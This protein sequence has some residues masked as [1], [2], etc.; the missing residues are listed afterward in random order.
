MTANGSA[1]ATNWLDRPRRRPLQ[2]RRGRPAGRR[3]PATAHARRGAGLE[4]AGRSRSAPARRSGRRPS[5]SGRRR[6]R[7]RHVRAADGGIAPVV[8]LR[9][10]QPADRAPADPARL[11][12]NDRRV[13][14]PDER[15]AGDA[16]GGGRRLL[17]HPRRTGS[18]RQRRPPP[19]LRTHDRGDVPHAERGAGAPVATKQHSVLSHAAAPDDLSASTGACS[20]QRFC[21]TGSST[22]SS[23][24]ARIWIAPIRRPIPRWRSTPASLSMRSASPAGSRRRFRCGRRCIC[25]YRKAA[26]R[27]VRSRRRLVSRCG[28]CS[29]AWTPRARSSPPCSTP[30]AGIWRN[31]ACRARPARSARSRELLGYSQLSSFSR[32]FVGEFQD[33]ANHV[34]A[35]TRCRP[36][37]TLLR[38]RRIGHRPPDAGLAQSVEQLIVIRRPR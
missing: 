27:S 38:T 33:L 19:G 26:R 31:S 7:L 14:P 13:S 20:A 5:G 28:P 22:R 4:R 15:G 32:W 11:A 23:A 12:G 29:G 24:G 30:S 35:C 6:V 36:P 37:R 8:G 3:Q 25:V 34:A 16:C 21:S 10:R 1:A 17:P 9:R 18:A 2:L